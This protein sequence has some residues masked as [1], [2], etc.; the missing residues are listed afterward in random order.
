MPDDASEKNSREDFFTKQAEE[1]FNVAVPECAF[2]GVVNGALEQLY[3]ARSAFTSEVQNTITV[4]A[5]LLAGAGFLLLNAIMPSQGSEGGLPCWQAA[6]AVLAGFAFLGVKKATSLFSDKLDAGYSLYATAVMNA[7]VVH[8]ACGLNSSH[9]W[10]EDVQRASNEEGAFFRTEAGWM[11]D[12]QCVLK[13]LYESD[14]GF[15][16]EVSKRTDKLHRGPDHTGRPKSNDELLAVWKA[17]PR[18][19][20]ALNKRT[21]QLAG[22]TAAILM[23]ASFL[24]GVV[25]GWLWFV[26]LSKEPIVKAIGG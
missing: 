8:K 20:L 3:S 13:R 6:V 10:L 25:H 19:L 2:E 17:S 9:V 4:V 11:S 22:R 1:Y 21:L 7:A 23:C 12:T 26:P 16:A 15:K 5:A 18:T 24:I 14:D